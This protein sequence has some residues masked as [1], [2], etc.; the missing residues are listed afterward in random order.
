[1]RTR[2]VTGERGLIVPGHPSRGVRGE[3]GG[4]ALQGDQILERSDIIKLD[5]LEFLKRI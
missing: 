1:M 4:M 5:L 3:F 2:R